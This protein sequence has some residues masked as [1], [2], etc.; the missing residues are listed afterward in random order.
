MNFFIKFFISNGESDVWSVGGVRKN[1]SDSLIQISIPNA[2]HMEDLF[3]ALPN[4][5]KA[6]IDARVQEKK[7]VRKWINDYNSKVQN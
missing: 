3:G 2:A 5:P 6:L 7:I 1:L 4:D